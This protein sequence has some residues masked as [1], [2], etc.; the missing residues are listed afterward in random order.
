MHGWASRWAVNESGFERNPE[1]KGKGHIAG[2]Q[3][4]LPSS[5]LAGR[6]ESP[7]GQVENVYI[8]VYYSSFPMTFKP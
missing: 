2:F 6:L 1:T 8:A 4:L 5:G 7:L 3:C